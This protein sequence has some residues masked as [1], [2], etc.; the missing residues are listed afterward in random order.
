MMEWWVCGN[1]ENKISFTLRDVGNN[2]NFI[3]SLLLEFGN[4]L[5]TIG[6]NKWL[7]IH[8]FKQSLKYTNASY[9]SLKKMSSLKKKRRNGMIERKEFR[10]SA[11][12]LQRL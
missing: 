11:S 9:L 8:Y 2:K 1:D 7:N 3:V 10:I 4:K 5:I 6:S 12:S